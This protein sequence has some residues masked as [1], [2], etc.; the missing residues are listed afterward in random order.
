MQG[1]LDSFESRIKD[2]DDGVQP[3][4]QRRFCV[5]CKDKFDEG[6]GSTK[7]FRRRIRNDLGRI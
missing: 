3:E 2:K 6:S 1:R 5:Q 4:I 7:A